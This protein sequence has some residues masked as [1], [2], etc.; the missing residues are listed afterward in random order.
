MPKPG[1]CYEETFRIMLND[2]T[3]AKHGKIVHG[4]VQDPK[5]HKIL[6][7]AWIEVG[8]IVI[9]PTISEGFLEKA[10]YYNVVNAKPEKYY[11]ELQAI[12]QA[13]KLKKGFRKW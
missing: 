5:T 11:T 10:K 7:H 6:D 2:D 1:L 8:A 9:D 12:N 13:F 4:T 3:I